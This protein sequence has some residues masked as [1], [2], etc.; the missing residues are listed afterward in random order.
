MVISAVVRNTDTGDTDTNGDSV[1]TISTGDTGDVAGETRHGVNGD[2][3]STGDTNTK[4]TDT[5]TKHGTPKTMR[6]EPVCKNNTRHAPDAYARSRTPRVRSDFH[7]PHNK[8][9]TTLVTAKSTDA[10]RV[11]NKQARLVLKR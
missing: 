1:S 5:N 4:N 3:V 2:S 11:M 9:R 6:A 8:T 7:A 10:N